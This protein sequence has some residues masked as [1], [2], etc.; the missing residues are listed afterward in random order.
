MRRCVLFAL[1]WLL[2]GAVLAAT[3]VMASN[4]RG[5]FVDDDGSV[6]E[7]DINGLW[8]AGIT[9]GCNPPVDDR[10]CPDNPVTRAQ[11]ASLLVRALALTP[12]TTSP[13]TDITNNVHEAD[14]RALA[15]AGITTGCNPPANNRYCP[16]N[17]VTRAQMASLLVRS[18]DDVTPRRNTL[19]MRSGLGCG[20]DGLSCTRRITLA[21]GIRLEVREG[22]YQVLPYLPGESEAFRAG[23]T[24]V[25]FSWNGRPLDPTFLGLVEGSTTS[26]RT[27]RV[28]PPELAQGTHVLRATWQWNG[29]TTQTVTALITVP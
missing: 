12:T 9:R 28:R 16:D 6:H 11:M 25:A 17:P 5:A 7:S 24:R 23:G 26:T 8:V 18:L 4:G 14:I 19:S 3:P 21:R 10:Y 13:F 29:S 15:A 27:W 22:W 20:K 2:A 1:P